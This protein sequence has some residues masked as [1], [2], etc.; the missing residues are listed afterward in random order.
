MALDALTFRTDVE[1]AQGTNLQ[2]LYMKSLT[3]AARKT[4]PDWKIGEF[5][6]TE[7]TAFKILHL[8]A[9]DKTLFVLPTRAQN[10]LLLKITDVP[11]VAITNI[12]FYAPM[13]EFTSIQGTNDFDVQLFLNS[14]VFSPTLEQVKD[15]QLRTKHK[16]KS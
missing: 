6:M 7:E 4:G 1:T 2:Q 10:R 11:Y 13:T 15:M 9:T 12:G 14:F 8:A 3:N 16:N 5:E